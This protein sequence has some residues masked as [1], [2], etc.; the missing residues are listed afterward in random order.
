[1]Y[2][3]IFLKYFWDILAFCLIMCVGIFCQFMKEASPFV[4]SF[5]F[6][7]FEV[8]QNIMPLVAL[9][10]PLMSMER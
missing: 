7:T 10:V 9:L 5:S 2:I 1:M 6:V 4:F 3:I 8:S